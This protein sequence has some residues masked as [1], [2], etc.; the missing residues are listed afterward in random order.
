MLN[1]ERDTLIKDPVLNQNWRSERK[2]AGDITK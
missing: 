2:K 1:A